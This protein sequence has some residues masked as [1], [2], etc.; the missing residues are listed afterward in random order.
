MDLH[1]D[2][3]KIWDNN[4]IISSDTNTGGGSALGAQKAAE[5]EA[6][7]ADAGQTG[8]GGAGEM[9]V[10]KSLQAKMHELPSGSGPDPF[11]APIPV[12]QIG[13]GSEFW[14]QK[15]PFN[16]GF[17]FFFRCYLW[18]NRVRFHRFRCD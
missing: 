3:T 4:G 11:A 6:L 16:L 18:T 14:A 9:A 10:A 17:G 12:D 13:T 2:G 1:E 5:Q 15:T 7:R 8:G